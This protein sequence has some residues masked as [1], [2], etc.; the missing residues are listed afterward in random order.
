MLGGSEA[1]EY[2]C[3]QHNLIIQGMGMVCAATVNGK[4]SAIIPAADEI[5]PAAGAALYHSHDL[6]RLGQVLV[7]NGWTLEKLILSE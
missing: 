1:N 7:G 6:I 4:S 2:K 3:A 5:I